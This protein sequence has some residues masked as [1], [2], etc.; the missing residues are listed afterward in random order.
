MTP[1]SRF[2]W[3][4]SLLFPLA[5]TAAEPSRSDVAVGVVPRTAEVSYPPRVP[6]GHRVVFDVVVS[7]TG[8][9]VPQDV[10]VDID[11]PGAVDAITTPDDGTIACSGMRPIRCTVTGRQ[12]FYQGSIRIATTQTQAGN[13]TAVASITTSSFDDFQ[14]NNRSTATFEVVDRP[15]LTLY[16]T[17]VYRLEPGQAAGASVSVVNYG[18]P[19]QNVTL[20]LTLPAGGSFQNATVLSGEA[21]CQVDVSSIVCRASRLDYW[22]VLRVDMGYTAADRLDG[23]SMIVRASATSDQPDLDAADNTKDLRPQLVAHLLVTNTADEGAGSLRQA[24]LDA[25]EHCAE[26]P[27]TVDFRIPPPVPE[28]GW[29]T[30]RPATPLPEVWGMVKIDGGGRIAIDGSSLPEGSNGLVLR[31]SCDVS[32]V[33]LAINGFPRHAIEYRDEGPVPPCTAAPYYPI[34]ARNHLAGNERG[35]VQSA[36]VRIEIVD[37]V[38]RG[39]RRAGIFIGNGFLAAI[40]GNTIIENGASGV[41]LNVGRSDRSTV[42]GA[43]VEHNVIANNGEWGICRTPN[44]AIAVRDNSIYGNVSAGIDIGLDNDTPNREN[45]AFTVPN[46]PE[47]FSAAY[48]AASDTTTVRGRLSSSGPFNGGTFVIDV[49][50]SSSLSLW[51]YAQGERLVAMKAFLGGRF[52]FEIAVPGDL[53]GE[54]ITATSTRSHVV[55]WAKPPLEQSHEAAVPSETSEFSNPVEGR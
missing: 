4:L 51:G 44:G 39:N 33:D 27:C 21:A 54:F 35:I 47:L 43:H 49:Y 20:T 55:G 37:N 30:I 11:V 12:A 52:D 34:I 36:G 2:S 48:D 31:T 10:V 16:G 28:E 45:D 29:F 15:S 32:V 41:F 14:A 5:L 38:I 19:A 6:A 26:S 18:V 13:F 23:A 3:F 22:Q 42:A 46:K 50:A 24:L 53:R 17:T 1:V 40:R 9:D 8:F 7:W 25:R